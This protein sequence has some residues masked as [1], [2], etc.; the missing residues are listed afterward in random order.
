MEAPEL[1]S[2]ALQHEQSLDSTAH[3]DTLAPPRDNLYSPRLRPV[4]HERVGMRLA[5]DS[6]ARPSVDNH[7]DVRGGNVRVGVDVV[8]AEDAGEQLGRVDGVQLGGHV[9]GLLLG[10]GRDDVGVVGVRPR[11]G[12]VAFEQRADGHFGHILG[13]VGV[14]LDFVEAD[15]I[16]AVAGGGEVA[17]HVEMLG[18]LSCWWFCCSVVNC[19]VVM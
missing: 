2:C 9:G 11:G 5:V 4:A 10:V 15:V 19:C 13:L 18:S 14:A 16:L 7:A 17:G 1:R 3:A 12:D 6:H 8:L